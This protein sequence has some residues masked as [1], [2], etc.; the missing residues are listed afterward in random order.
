MHITNLTRIKLQIYIFT[1]LR[2][3]IINGN[4]LNVL[5]IQIM[6]IQYNQQLYLPFISYNDSIIKINTC[7]TNVVLK[8]GQPTLAIGL[9]V[10]SK[11]CRSI[12]GKNQ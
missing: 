9:H 4:N 6:F 1:H 7:H 11:Y 10:T 2:H 12:S 5:I 3:C 8:P